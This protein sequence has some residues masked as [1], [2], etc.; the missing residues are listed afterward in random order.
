LSPSASAGKTGVYVNGRQIDFAEAMYVRN[1]MG[2]V[3]PGR[4]WLD[5]ASG[6]SASKAIRSRSATCT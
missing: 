2:N 4:W 5:G 1:L 6:T 3:V